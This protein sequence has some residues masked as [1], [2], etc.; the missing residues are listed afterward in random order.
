MFSVKKVKSTFLLLFI[1]TSLIGQEDN[2]IVRVSFGAENEIIPKIKDTIVEYFYDTK[3]VKILKYRDENVFYKKYFDFNG[4]IEEI[5]YYPLNNLK[6]KTLIIYENNI[7]NYIKSFKFGL[8][9]G[10]YKE[11]Y[12]NGI[13]KLDGTYFEGSKVGA[14][15][16]FDKKGNLK[17]VEVY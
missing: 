5:A 4:I 17:K 1:T 7:I 11:F 8:I 15:L 3:R 14:W 12:K 10:R 9:H 13:L 2:S 16:S 6:F